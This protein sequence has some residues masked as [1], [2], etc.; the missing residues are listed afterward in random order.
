MKY[1]NQPTGMWGKQRAK[2]EDVD[3][4]VLWDWTHWS[5]SS[6]LKHRDAPIWNQL[7]MCAPKVSSILSFCL[8]TS[9]VST[10]LFYK[11]KIL[12][13]IYKLQGKKFLQESLGQKYIKYLINS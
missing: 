1:R 9:W 6:E 10:L 4:H 2:D 7:N 12:S 11:L 13:K 8:E 3:V 5:H